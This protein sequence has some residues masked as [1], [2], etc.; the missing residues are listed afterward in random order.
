MLAMR[1]GAVIGAF[2]DFQ[3]L[4]QTGPKP[5]LSGI[6][7][8]GQSGWAL[9]DVSWDGIVAPGVELHSSARRTS[10]KPAHAVDEANIIAGMIRAAMRNQCHSGIVIECQ[11]IAGVCL[12]V[13]DGWV[14]GIS[15]TL[16]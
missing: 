6:V 8:W 14:V 15:L 1:D 10:P 11:L 5:A 7:I 2:H 13:N 16:D 3:G 4:R 12:L 9:F